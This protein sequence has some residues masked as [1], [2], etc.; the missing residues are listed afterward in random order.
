LCLHF[1]MIF[2]SDLIFYNDHFKIFY[3]IYHYFRHL[4]SFL[5][6]SIILKNYRCDYFYRFSITM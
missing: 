5:L 3:L 4:F 1:S 2:K 6:D